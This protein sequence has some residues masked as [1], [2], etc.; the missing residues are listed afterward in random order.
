MLEKLKQKETLAQQAYRAIKKAIIQGEFIPND[1]LPEEK[2]AEDLG[3]SRTPLREALNQLAFEGLIELEKGK[4]ARVAPFTEENFHQFIELRLLLEPLN[5]ER[6]I[7]PLPS[8]FLHELQHSLETQQSAIHTRD[9]NLFIEEDT[10]FH[11]LLAQQGSNKK[12]ADFINQLNSSLNR[13]FLILSGTLESSA[14][15]AYLEH[16]RIYQHLKALNFTKACDEMSNH[17]EHI[18]KRLKQF[19]IKGE[20]K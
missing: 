2:L 9:F 6:L 18:E 3:I 10:R 14:Q 13:R 15:E 5:L 7:L 11:L 20:I 4:K 16:Q 17:I 1:T 19:Q 12:L 8:S